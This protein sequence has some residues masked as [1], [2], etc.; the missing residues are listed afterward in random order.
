[1]DKLEVHTSTKAQ[2]IPLPQTQ[3][4]A[5]QIG[6]DT[7]IH[8]LTS[9]Y[10]DLFSGIG[11][12]KHFELKLHINPQVKPVAQSERRTPFHIR[13]KV[14]QE[15]DNLTKQG[16]IEPCTGPKPWD[17][18]LVV[19][20][21]PKNSEEIIIC[22]DMRLPNTAIVVPPGQENVASTNFTILLLLLLG[23]SVKTKHNYIHKTNYDC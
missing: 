21:K 17:S 5:D 6:N 20:P 12:L 10:H 18:P 13:E 15:L 8:N 16:I 3:A 4:K 23:Q 22:V 2:D 9:E 19:T 7:F 11:C 1:M 14:N